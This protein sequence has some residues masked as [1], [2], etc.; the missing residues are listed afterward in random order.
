PSTSLPSYPVILTKPS[1]LLHHVITRE[2]ARLAIDCRRDIVALFL[3]EAWRLNAERCQRDPGAA[4]SSALF[5]RHRQ[6]PTADSCAAPILGQKKPTNI[7]EP[8]FG[9]S[10]EPAYD[11]AGLWIADEHG[12]WAKIVVS[13]LAQIIRT[14]TIA[15]YRCVGG[16]KLIGDS[17]V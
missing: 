6:H 5:F 8:E 3:V 16:I 14:Q 13:G 12:E 1:E 4:A 9:S 7:D 10:V 17:D 11:L 15:D 2:A